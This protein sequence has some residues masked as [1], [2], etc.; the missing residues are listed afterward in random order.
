MKEVF[1]PIDIKNVSG[2]SYFQDTVVI[3][4][5]IKTSH[6]TFVIVF[7]SYNSSLR[8]HSNYRRFRRFP[9]FKI[10]PS[11]FVFP[12]EFA[13]LSLPKANK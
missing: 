4:M 5:L 10:P 11:I 6:D 3:T 9:N 7:D 13:S 12:L 8:P 2:S 1:I